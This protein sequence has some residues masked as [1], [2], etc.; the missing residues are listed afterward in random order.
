MAE[1]LDRS[2]WNARYAASDLVRSTE[3]NRF[4]AAELAGRPP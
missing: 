1:A 4:V 2:A 3:P